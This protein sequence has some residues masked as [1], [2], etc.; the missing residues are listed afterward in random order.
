M[1]AVTIRC[2]YEPNRLL[3]GGVTGTALLLQN[4]TRFPVGL[5][6]LL[7]N[8]PVFL[9]GFRDVGRKFVFFSGLGVFAFWMFADFLPLRPLTFDPMLGAI[10]G[11]VLAGLG[12]SLALKAGGSLGGF[13]IIG[14]YINRRFS[15]GVG[16][17]LIALNGLLVLA[18]GI[19]ASPEAAMHT[20]IGIFTAGRVLD[21]MQIPRPRKAFL[22]VTSRP[23]GIT[24]RV[25]DEMKRGLTVWSAKGGRETD[26]T[27]LLCVV[28][29]AE[30]RELADLV[31]DEDRSAFT[32]VLEASQ[33]FGHFRKRGTLESI[34][35]IHE[36]G[37]AG[38]RP[39]DRIL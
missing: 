16:E 3:S 5:G 29:R 13:D 12:T 37:G 31:R 1:Y 11:G 20:L 25:Q 10:F 36:A 14:V 6:V 23:E 9:L 32:V 18:A 30:I 17:V 19:T 34:R 28:T 21:A 38:T 8:I 33:V 22:I 4:L 39:D 27:I 15:T 7:L 26:R 2:F 24:R 35:R